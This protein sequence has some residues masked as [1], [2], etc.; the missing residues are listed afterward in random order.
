MIVPAHNAA[1]TIGR[2]LTSLA[3]Q[4]LE[5]PY[6]VIVVD[7]GSVDRTVEV[8]NTFAP[9]MQIRL[10]RQEQ[11]GPAAARNAG[12]AASSGEM[13]A[14]TDADCYATRGWLAAGVQGLERAELVQGAVAP[15]P[16][17]ALGPW[18]RTLWVERETGLYETAN[19][20]VRRRLLEELGG[21]EVWLD[22]KVGKPIAEDVWFGWRARR[23]GARTA[24]RADALVHHA[25]F[26]RGPLGFLDE[27]RRLQYFPAMA[28]KMPEL[29]RQF[30]AARYFL[31]PRTAA[32]DAALLGVAL[33]AR[34]RSP[35]ALGACA[36][37]VR[38]LRGR[39]CPTADAPR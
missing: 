1:E 29:R 39:H 31:A 25:V 36:P 35:V 7:D 6:E 32:F 12:V 23:A 21:F 30:F 17:A 13:L 28:S 38:L 34:T 11:R 27:R 14:F 18:D 22:P 33:A 24:F 20:F 26:P 3:E 5:A 19:L 37:Y 8:V 10:I 4:D 9:S 16:A 15:D 2:A